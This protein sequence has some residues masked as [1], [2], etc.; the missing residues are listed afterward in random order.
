MAVKPLRCPHCGGVV[1]TFDESMKK[2]FCPFCDTLIED[3]QERQAKMME[4]VPHKIKQSKKK[5]EQIS[6]TLRLVI[7]ILLFAFMTGM[8]FITGI[9]DSSHYACEWKD[10]FQWLPYSILLV[11]SFGLMAWN[12]VELIAN[13]RNKKRT[14]LKK[15]APIFP[16]IFS[17]IV[18]AGGILM[19]VNLNH[20]YQTQC[21]AGQL[22]SVGI[23]KNDIKTVLEDLEKFS[24]YDSSKE[25]FGKNADHSLHFSVE[26]ENNTYKISATDF[27]LQFLSNNSGRYYFNV[28]SGHVTE[29][30]NVDDY[31]NRIY[32]IKDGLPT[33]NPIGKRALLGVYGYRRYNYEVEQRIKTMLKSPSTAEFNWGYKVR[34]DEKNE[35]I[36]VYGAV[37]AQNSYGGTVREKFSVTLKAY[38]DEEIKK[39]NNDDYIPC[40][41]S[42]DFPLSD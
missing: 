27:S 18:L 1:E 25:Y 14:P 21:P 41:M 4:I 26:L 10:L 8:F 36:F 39:V 28:E 37:D 9:S 16:L 24:L 30:Y 40:K 7:A 2:G 3:V 5:W 32:I 22:L 12:I 34:F 11:T 38:T 17:C 35:K 31:S 13:I 23:A 20:I 42:I 33:N 15:K 6:I 19:G 29:V